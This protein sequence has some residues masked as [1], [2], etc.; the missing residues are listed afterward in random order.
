MTNPCCFKLLCSQAKKP[1]RTNHCF[2]CDACV[3]K[4]DHHSAWTNGCIGMAD[5]DSQKTSIIWNVVVVWEHLLP[6][7]IIY[8]GLKWVSHQ[9]ICRLPG[10]RNHHYFVLFL[11]SLMMMGA[12]MFYGCIVCEWLNING[13]ITVSGKVLDLHR[14]QMLGFCVFFR[15]VDSLRAALWGSGPVGSGVW[16]GQLLSMAAQHLPAGLLSRLLV[17]LGPGDTALPGDSLLVHNLLSVLKP[18][19]EWRETSELTRIK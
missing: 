6:P 5:C 19:S 16:P 15:L 7:R 8:R 1:V 3:A 17:R 18:Y 13:L 2:S 14:M 11:F 9:H 10:A 12:W 4:Q